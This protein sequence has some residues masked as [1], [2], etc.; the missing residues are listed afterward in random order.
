ML[1]AA[2]STLIALLLLLPTSAPRIL[3]K[4]KFAMR[5]GDSGRKIE[6]K[7]RGGGNDVDGAMLVSDD[8]GGSVLTILSSDIALIQLNA[9]VLKTAS[10]CGRCHGGGGT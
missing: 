4:A 1:A 7:E 2:M 10:S 5:K 9:G 8:S 3:R 6:A